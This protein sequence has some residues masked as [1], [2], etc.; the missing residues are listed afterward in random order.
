MSGLIPQRSAPDAALTPSHGDVSAKPSRLRKVLWVFALVVLFLVAAAG[1]FVLGFPAMVERAGRG[2]IGQLEA[3]LGVAVSARA[4]D[5]SLSGDVDV[6]DLVVRD[7]G[8]PAGEAPL[9]AAPSVRVRADVALFDQKVTLRDIH[10][11]APVIT[12]VRRPDGSGNLRVLAQ[13]LAELLGDRAGGTGTGGGGPL[14]Y[15]ERR[16]P[17]LSM[18]HARVIVDAPMPELPLG[19]AIPDVVALNDG[20][21]TVTADVPD[22]PSE[23]ALK[24]DF[25]ETSLDPGFGLG[26]EL[27]V[28]LDGAP[29]VVGAR[30]DRPV[31]FYLGQRVAGVKGFRWTPEGFAVSELQLSVPI[32]PEKSRGTVGAAATVARLEVAPEPRE[33][34]RRAQADLI[35]EGGKPGLRDYLAYVDKLVVVEPALVLRLAAGGHHSFGDLVPALRWG[36]RKRTDPADLLVAAARAASAQLG[37][38]KEAAPEGGTLGA[39]VGRSVTALDRL[40][41][42]LAP[43]VLRV[44]DGL[45]LKAL[46]VQRGHVSLS[47]P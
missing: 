18:A 38:T 30:F 39:R 15:L 9:L 11:E 43:R 31:R 25:A 16:A 29:H 7:P 46:E 24:A 26:V 42:V 35:E 33:I 32:D 19:L 47:S 17:G 12:V 41:S 28:G 8:A 2:A 6:V 36:D 27:A 21:I 10:L 45:P 40:A 3:R 1:G 13:R 34:L 4:V 23:V 5:W 20:A 14:R 44:L 37:T 22:A